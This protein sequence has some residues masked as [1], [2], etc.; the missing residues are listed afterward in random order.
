MI[1]EKKSHKLELRVS[2]SELELI[3][4]A[5]GLSQTKRS[6]YVRWNILHLAS[7]AVSEA[8]RLSLD[9]RDYDRLQAALDEP[10]R[11]LPRLKRLLA[12][13]SVFGE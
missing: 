10:V 7:R 13:A 4:R 8:E 5:A 9:I 1:T 3:D 11:P 6:Q 2:A 12:E